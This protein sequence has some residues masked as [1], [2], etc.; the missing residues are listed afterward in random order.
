MEIP[1]TLAGGKRVVAEIK[2]MRVE[3]DQPREAGGEAVAPS[4]FDLFL[5]SLATCSGYYVLD[6]C[7]ARNI[8]TDD[9]RIT[10]RTEVDP[11][12]RMIGKVFVEIELPADF[13]DRYRAP[14][15]RAADLCSVKKH[16]LDPPR[17]ETYATIGGERV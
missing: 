10:M 17:F 5:A 12:K 1:V 15:V 16:I 11:A 6:F 9:I 14:V 2:G 8:P 4:P 3:T 13:P 7:L